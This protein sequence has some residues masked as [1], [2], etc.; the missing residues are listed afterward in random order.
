MEFKIKPLNN[1]EF[2]DNKKLN[3]LVDNNPDYA[4]C[5]KIMIIS[6]V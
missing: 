2:V 1:V 3:I 5:K 6:Y 4:N